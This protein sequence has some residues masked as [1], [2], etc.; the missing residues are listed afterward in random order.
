VTDRHDEDWEDEEHPERP[1]PGRGSSTPEGVRILGAEEARAAMDAGGVT[2]RLGDQDTRYGDV[3]AR[4]DPTIRPSARFPRPADEPLPELEPRHDEPLGSGAP[5]PA[6]RDEP[7]EQQDAPRGPESG[8]AFGEFDGPEGAPEAQAE[9]DTAAWASLGDTTRAEPDEPAAPA[10]PAE[11]VD[12]APSADAEPLPLPHW[13]EPPTGEMPIILPESEPLDLTG[14][15]EL[16]AFEAAASAQGGPRFRTGVDDWADED[17]TPIGELA[18]DTTSVGELGSPREDDDA[19]FDREVA[20]R[21]RIHTRVSSTP[22]PAPA[23]A[24][25]RSRFS[26]GPARR[27]ADDEVDEHA[28]PP[29]DMWTRVITGVAIIVLAL[30]CFQLGREATMLLATL[31]VALATFELFQGLHGR[32]FRPATILAVVGSIAI[33]PIAFDRGEFAFPFTLAIVTIFTLLWYLFEVVRTRPVVNVSATIGGFVYVG[34]LGGFAGLLLSYADGV[35]LLLGAVICVVAYDV[36][37]YFVGSQFGKTRLAPAISPNKTW[38]GLIGG[39]TASVV[40]AVLVVAQI[41]PWGSIGD[42]LALG[43]VVAVLAPLGDLCESLLKRDLGIKDFGTLLPGHGG[44]LDRFD[45]L[46][47]CLPAVYYLALALD[48][49]HT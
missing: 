29:P 45:A 41:A 12:V 31:V 8:F 1:A 39:M 3:P 4:P 22:E 7:V 26:R 28:A 14:E 18:D 17:Y 27:G 36:V 34:V 23:P 30:I 5:A 16:T 13:S 25:P 9:D 24:A 20:A 15:D 47:F 43:L 35:G 2:R 38:E 19:A 11:A 33:V 46:L 42:A 40:A 32:G 44:I 48:I 37:G 49:I 6:A 10:D 21:R